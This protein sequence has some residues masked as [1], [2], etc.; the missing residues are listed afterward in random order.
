MI[1]KT[2]TY[3]LKAV[4]AHYY[5]NRE[6]KIQQVKDNNYDRKIETWLNDWQ[7]ILRPQLY[8]PPQ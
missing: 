4:R 8:R 7:F 2:K 1:P 6:K 5:R 3:T